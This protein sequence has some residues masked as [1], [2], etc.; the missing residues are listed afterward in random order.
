[1][2]VPVVGVGPQGNKFEQV[3]SDDYQMSVAGRTGY[4]G[5]MSEERGQSIMVPCSGGEGIMVPYLGDTLSSD[6]PNNLD[7]FL[8]LSR[9]TDTCENITFTQLRWRVV[10]IVPLWTTDARVSDSRFKVMKEIVLP[11]NNGIEKR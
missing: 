5:P 3:S 11:L 8:P 4:P 9:K 6:L 7:T 10:K 1:M 2:S